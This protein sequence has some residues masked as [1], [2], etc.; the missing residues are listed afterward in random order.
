MF[1]IALVIFP[2]SILAFLLAEVHYQNSVAASLVLL[3]EAR[4]NLEMSSY[5]VLA[6]ISFMSVVA[7]ATLFS[8]LCAKEKGKGHPSSDDEDSSEL[9]SDSD[10]KTDD[11]NDSDDSDHESDFGWVQIFNLLNPLALTTPIPFNPSI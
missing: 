6:S 3:E 4:Y 8:Y 11:S 5:L 9:P 2:F 7:I 10:S 1:R